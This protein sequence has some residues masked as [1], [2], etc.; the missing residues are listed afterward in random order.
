[1]VLF[2][3]LLAVLETAIGI[4]ANLEDLFY[5]L[6]NPNTLSEMELIK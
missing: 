6:L 1:M 3:M 5:I 2:L 4:I